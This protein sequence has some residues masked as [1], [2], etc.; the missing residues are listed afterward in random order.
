MKHPKFHVGQAVVCIDAHIDGPSSVPTPKKGSIYRIKNPVAWK[1]KGG[2]EVELY[3]FE[4]PDSDSFY[5]Y[6]D[7]HFAPVELASDEALA[8]LLEETLE[9]ITT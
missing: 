3:E 2:W 1:T 6:D 5:S 4:C 7:F 8:Q 9:P